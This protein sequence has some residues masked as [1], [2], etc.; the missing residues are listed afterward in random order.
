MAQKRWVKVQVAGMAVLAAA[1]AAGTV[2]GGALQT[3]DKVIGKKG[4]F[5]V[6]KQ[7]G[8][9]AVLDKE[10]GL[11]W[12]RSPSTA[13]A[14]WFT[15]VALCN[16]R[17]VGGRMGW[18]LPT[19]VELATLMDRS[20][21]DPALPPNHPFMNVQ[22]GP[23]DLYWSATTHPEHPDN[24]WAAGFNTGTVG[25]FAQ[26]DPAVSEYVW[27]VRAPGGYDGGH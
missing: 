27:C 11:V 16:A 26:K 3:W 10:T 23:T 6:L 8:Q 5:K 9:E 18:R 24:A 21:S 2:H 1:L 4:R 13:K 22:H 14:S 17:E 19:I 25:S 15:A 20:Q 12:E 7:F